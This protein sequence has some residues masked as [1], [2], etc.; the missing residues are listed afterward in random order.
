MN[1]AFIPKACFDAALSSSA[2]QGQRLRLV[3]EMCRANALAAVKLAGSGH[4]GSSL[5]AMDVVAWLHFKVM[6]TVSAGAGHPDR[7]IFFSSKGHDA[8]GYYAVLHAAGIAPESLLKN[9]RRQGGYEGHPVVGQPGIEAGTGSLGM[10]LSKGAG[11]AE[12]KRLLGRG[13][14]V[15]VMTGDGELQE[16]Q[17]YEAMRRAAARGLGGLVAVVDHNRVQSDKSV[18]DT[19]P[20]GDLEAKFRAFGWAVTRC[21]GHSFEEL[22]AALATLDACGDVPKA[23]IADTLKGR[24]VSFMEHPAALEAGGGFYRW[25]AGA[26]DDETFLAAH[27]EVLAR[28]AALADAA[29]VS[30]LPGWEFS[31]VASFPPAAAPAARP[32]VA[33]AYGHALAELGGQRADLVVLDA[34][35]G[36]DCRLR[37]FQKRFPDRFFEIGIAEQDMVSVAGGMALQGLTPVVNS[38][39][40]FMVSRA[41]EQ[42]Y[43][44]ACEGTK[45]I[46]ACHY[47]GLLPA[48]AGMSHQSVRDVSL[49]GAMPG[50]LVVEPSDSQET[51]DLLAYLVNEA[52]GPSAI[53]LFLGPSPRDLPFPASRRLVPGRG[54]VLAQPG[55]A[56]LFSYG[57]VMLN[58]SLAA[59]EA[60]D[61]LGVVAM[62]WLNLVD[63]GWLEEVLTG[64]EH[65]FIL[66]DH[67][68]VGGLGAAMLRALAEGGLLRGRSVEVFGVEGL[69]RC[70]QPAEVLRAHGLDG[71]SLAER[72]RAHIGR[73][74][75]SSRAR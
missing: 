9:L 56:M 73:L 65:V 30:R 57:P 42:I 14:R 21:D 64:V 3:S 4:M 71:Q 52:Q 59:A 7:D 49:L 38:F 53:R 61:G 2:P 72:V 54:T 43:A 18:E 28:V 11:M 48:A 6:N 50:F 39:A 33:D 58:E 37:E 29:G 8:P 36:N 45:V 74:D 51:R 47:G 10:G 40:A 34:D 35:L 13:G 22:D 26:P 68:P 27:G 32:F 20:L 16:G 17:N 31:N 1:I 44:N 60:C 23:I 25:H 69:P 46:H 19:A 41:N 67:S 24:G 55:S 66:D 12:A 62:P 5:S 70:G 63:A 75:R 15:F